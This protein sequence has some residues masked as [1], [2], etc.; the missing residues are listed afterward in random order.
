MRLAVTLYPEIV[1]LDGTYKLVLCGLTV[2]LI[3]VENADGESVVVG[4][5]LVLQEDRDT[6]EWF[7]TAFKGDNED[8]L[9]KL[10]CLMAD[11]DLLQRDVLKQVF[12]GTPVYVYLPFS[13]LNFSR[14]SLLFKKKE[15]FIILK[16]E[17]IKYKRRNIHYSKKKKKKKKHSLC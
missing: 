15:T 11:K 13:R 8:A 7:L 16:K 6:F 10:N 1:L 4:V 5:A 14:F 12:P 9:R 17:E 3:V 2:M